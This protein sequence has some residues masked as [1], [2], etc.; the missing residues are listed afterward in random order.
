MSSNL[1]KHLNSPF[2]KE[3]HNFWEAIRQKQIKKGSETY[4]EPFNP[5][6]WSPEELL[7][8][9]VSEVVDSNHY[10]FGLYKQI[11]FMKERISALEK[12][13]KAL[14]MEKENMYFLALR[15][16]WSVRDDLDDFVREFNKKGE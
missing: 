16:D 4:P 14:M 12:Q 10:A 15:A 2:Y 7:E 8:H 11:Q 6:S 9:F 3:S 5:F 1:E 13:N